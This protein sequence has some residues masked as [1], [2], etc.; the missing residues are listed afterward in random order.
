MSVR[1]QADLVRL[2]QAVL[3]FI[4][5]DQGRFFNVYHSS[6]LMQLLAGKGFRFNQDDISDLKIVINELF[7]ERII[8]PGEPGGGVGS[9]G[10]SFGH[11]LLTPHG[12]RV[13]ENPDYEPH[14]AEGYLARLRQE[15]PGTDPVIDAYLVEAL[16]C[17]RHG[18]H[19][20][21]AVMLGAA[22][23]KAMLGLI[24]TMKRGLKDPA[25]DKAIE[26]AQTIKQKQEAVTKFLPDPKTL[27]GELAERLPQAVEFVFHTLRIARN[28]AGHP[29][30]RFVQPGVVHGNL[31]LFP[32]YLRTLKDL[33]AHF[34]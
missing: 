1:G 30:G 34:V 10:W 4:R 14:D 2:R 26:R 13:L 23:E 7:L 19:L 16:G 33:D 17:Y 5:T 9:E 18:F 12:R 11:Y 32:S 24:E 29:T 25:F 21:S 3:E 8:V 15:V 22:S 27:P 20:A 28:D 6:A 31:V